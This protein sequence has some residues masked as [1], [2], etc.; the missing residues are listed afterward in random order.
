ME[1]YEMK[2]EILAEINAQIGK[3]DTKAGLL[4]SVIGIVFAVSADL[5]LVYSIDNFLNLLPVF[6]FF[7]FFIT[8]LYYASFVFT[9]VMFIL[10]IVP[11]KN[12]RQKNFM[13]NVFILTTIKI[14]LG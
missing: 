8:N 5:L 4:V 7:C 13:R 6:V 14:Y 9:I 11:R 1:R 2:R 3:M 12:T 10:T